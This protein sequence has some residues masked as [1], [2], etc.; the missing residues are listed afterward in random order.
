MTVTTIQ[1]IRKQLTVRASQEKAFEVF[2]A[3]MGRW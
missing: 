3:G 2:T 1:P